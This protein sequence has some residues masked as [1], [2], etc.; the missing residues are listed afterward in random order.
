MRIY[1]RLITWQK[2]KSLTTQFVGNAWRQQ[3]LSFIVDKSTKWF[4][5]KQEN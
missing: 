4:I 5:I 2:P 1:F 3:A